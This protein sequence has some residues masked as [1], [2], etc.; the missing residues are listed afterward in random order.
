MNWRQYFENPVPEWQR[1]LLS[2]IEI[3]AEKQA[4]AAGE[5]RRKPESWL[6]KLEA[7]GKMQEADLLR[8]LVEER[9]RTTL[10]LPREQAIP[11]DQPLQELGLDS[12]LSIELRN[13][14][15]M[16]LQRPLPATLLFDYPTLSALTEYLLSV[17]GARG[18]APL[19]EPHAKQGR[20]SVLEDIESLSDEEVERMLS[21][22]AG[23]ERTEQEVL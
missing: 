2:E 5:K 23:T 14:V 6:E 7:A 20:R 22:R 4:P 15:G 21:Q 16:S 9:I 13:S 1:R 10:R 3:R 17:V 8:G 12:L 19:E 11:L 18:S